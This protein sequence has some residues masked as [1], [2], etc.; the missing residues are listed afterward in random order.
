MNG[1]TNTDKPCCT[2]V[3]SMFHNHF[4][5]TESSFGILQEAQGYGRTLP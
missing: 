2:L 5:G 4:N 3:D 1:I